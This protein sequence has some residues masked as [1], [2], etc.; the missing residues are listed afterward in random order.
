MIY[1]CFGWQMMFQSVVMFHAFCVYGRFI[2][3]IS[4]S[5]IVLLLE[6]LCFIKSPH[7][8]PVFLPLKCAFTIKFFD[9]FLIFFCHQTISLS[10]Q[11]KKKHKNKQHDTNS[12]PYLVIILPAANLLPP[13]F[14]IT[15]R[16]HNGTIVN[17]QKPEKKS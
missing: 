8:P 5:V 9:S 16:K 2:N 1:V 17:E 13:F 11:S 7:F 12:Q 10:S 3:C 15:T 6:S 14:Y 4:M